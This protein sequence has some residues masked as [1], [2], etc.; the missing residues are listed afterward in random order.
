MPSVREVRGADGMSLGAIGV[1]VDGV[2]PCPGED[3]RG[4]LHDLVMHGADL[5]MARSI[6]PGGWGRPP[7][8]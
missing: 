8:D 5:G 4:S 6:A 2:G 7:V 3:A 1:E